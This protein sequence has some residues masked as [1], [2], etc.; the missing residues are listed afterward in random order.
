MQARF[1]SMNPIM[2]GGGVF[3]VLLQDALQYREGLFLVVLRLILIV[4]AVG[5]SFGQKNASL[6]VLGIAFYKFAI[7]LYFL[8]IASALV[9]LPG[10]V[11]GFGGLACF[12]VEAVRFAGVILQ[13]DGLGQR[14]VRVIF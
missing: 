5:K 11:G 9:F 7:N 13:T 10:F 3:G 1:D 6:H 8:R 12:D 14:L 2:I 4:I